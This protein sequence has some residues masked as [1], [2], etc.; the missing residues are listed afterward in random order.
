MDNAQW[1]ALIFIAF[2]VGIALGVF[3]G[4]LADDWIDRGGAKN[5]R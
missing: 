4:G 1:I 5:E 3:L 2:V